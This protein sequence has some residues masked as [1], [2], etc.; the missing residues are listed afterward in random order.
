MVPLNLD[1]IQDWITA[2][3]LNPAEPI[4]LKE[5]TA[6]RAVHSVKDG[7][8]L[9]ASGATKLNTAVN[10]VV[11]RASQSAI[12]AV[13]A[14]GGTVTTRFYTPLAIRRIRMGQ[15]HPYL[16]LKWDPA[17]MGN[18]AL[19]VPG[20]DSLEERVKGMGYEYRLPD[21]AGRKDLE[22]YRDAKNRGYLS[23]TVKEG[24]GPSL[25]FKPP[26]ESLAKAKSGQKS[27]KAKQKEEN[28]LW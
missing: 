14:L 11:S 17:A 3:R 27:R 6:S 8:K 9:L 2:G 20:A 16:S 13:E 22:Y 4:T 15:M 23:Y 24:E 12:A 1:R 26:K 7:V 18:P 10:I 25:Y 28:S 21:P 5:L 19:A